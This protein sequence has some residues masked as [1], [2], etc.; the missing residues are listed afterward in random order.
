MIKRC[1]IVF[2]IACL[3]LPPPAWADGAAI[4]QPAPQ[5][6]M[7]RKGKEWYYQMSDNT[8]KPFDHKLKGVR[9]NRMWAERFAQTEGVRRWR[10]VAI[11]LQPIFTIT[12]TLLEILL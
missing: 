6:L 11:T 5:L 7:V 2:A 9:D 12:L 3:I 1:L 4:V 10:A 8:L